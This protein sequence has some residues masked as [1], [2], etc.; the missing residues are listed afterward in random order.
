MK[1][2]YI[3]LVILNYAP[4]IFLLSENIISKMTISSGEPLIEIHSETAM[5]LFD[6]NSRVSLSETQEPSGAPDVPR[7]SPDRATSS[8]KT[9]VS[10]SPTTRT[11]SLWVSRRK[12]L[13][14]FAVKVAFEIWNRWN[15]AR[16][17]ARAFIFLAGNVTSVPARLTTYRSGNTLSKA[18]THA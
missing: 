17:R 16:A 13:C 18:Q 3:I 12:N 9:I 1:I 2:N 8:E 6:D 10:R 5:T 15:H 7:A 4:I 11:A 14:R